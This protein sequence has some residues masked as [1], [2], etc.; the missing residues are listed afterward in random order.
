M[1]A[2]LRRWKLRNGIEIEIHE[3]TH[4]YYGNYYNMKLIITSRI[5]TKEEYFNDLRETPNYGP[6]VKSLLPSVEYRREIVKAGVEG[7]KVAGLRDQ[8]VASFEESAL[9]Y[10]E[11]K[12]F[13]KSYARKRFREL[14]KK[15]SGRASQDGSQ[16]GDNP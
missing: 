10:F 2:F 16:N 12:G 13:A 8:L 3:D 5:E 4:R 9:P 1:A 6:I 14:Q 7:S 11:K 15:L